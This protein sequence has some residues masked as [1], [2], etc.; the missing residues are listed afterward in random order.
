MKLEEDGI[1]SER[2]GG[3]GK[4]SKNNDQKEYKA[5]CEAFCS[6]IWDKSTKGIKKNEVNILGIEEQV[7]Q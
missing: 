5:S 2:L 7:I 4:P 6:Q 3:S 1:S